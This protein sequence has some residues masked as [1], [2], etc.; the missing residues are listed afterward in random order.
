MEGAAYYNYYYYYYYFLSLRA[1]YYKD[2]YI[3][4]VT[5]PVPDLLKWVN[6]AT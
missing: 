4:S 2:S 1:V 5:A 3:S 6:L